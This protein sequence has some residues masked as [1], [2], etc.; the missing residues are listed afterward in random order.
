MIPNKDNIGPT[1]T[2]TTL[3]PQDRF[4]GVSAAEDPSMGMLPSNTSNLFDVSAMDIFGLLSGSDWLPVTSGGI[5]DI[6][7]MPSPGQRLARVK[8]CVG[9]CSA[10]FAC[11]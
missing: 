10:T 2:A 5:P 4:R 3:G 9:F 8:K 1:V 11:V 7:I 6:D